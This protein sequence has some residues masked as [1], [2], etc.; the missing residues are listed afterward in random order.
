MEVRLI[1]YESPHH[2]GR[3]VGKTVI[4]VS[5]NRT[6]KS[7]DRDHPAPFALLIQRALNQNA[8]EVGHRLSTSLSQEIDACTPFVGPP[9]TSPS[10]T[11]GAC[12]LWGN[13]SSAAEKKKENCRERDQEAKDGLAQAGLSGVICSRATGH[14]EQVVGPRSIPASIAL[15]QHAEIV[16]NDSEGSP[17]DA[18][19]NPA[20]NHQN[21]EAA[22]V[23]DHFLH[24]SS[25]QEDM[26]ASPLR[27]PAPNSNQNAGNSGRLTGPP[28]LDQSSCAS[29]SLTSTEVIGTGRLFSPIR[30]FLNYL[31]SKSAYNDPTKERTNFGWRRIQ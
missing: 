3:V 23:R 27:R 2:A 10:I 21:A 19:G 9:A 17:L 4:V 31:W 5:S 24:S 26:F 15:N 30:R 16:G 25:R 6:T 7:S 13:Q 1:D 14:E 12:K 28:V 29:Q 20:P 11:E 8:G 22:A 18:S